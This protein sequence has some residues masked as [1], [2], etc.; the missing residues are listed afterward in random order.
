MNKDNKTC[1]MWLVRPGIYRSPEKLGNVYCQRWRRNQRRN[2]VPDLIV[3]GRRG[4]A[5]DIK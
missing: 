2:D 1:P 3:R 5:M 4:W